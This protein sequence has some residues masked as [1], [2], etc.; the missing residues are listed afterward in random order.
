MY[1]LT[2]SIW[3]QIYSDIYFEYVKYVRF[4]KTSQ[5]KNYTDRIVKFLIKFSLMLII[6]LFFLIRCSDTSQFFISF[7]EIWCLKN[8]HIRNPSY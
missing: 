5:K 1:V 8:I 7:K 4:S 3:F 2:N 6:E